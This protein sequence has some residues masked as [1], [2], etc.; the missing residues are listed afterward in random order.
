MDSLNIDATKK[1]PRVKFDPSGKFCL[2]GRSI[3][4]DA[5]VFYDPLYLWIFEYCKNPAPKTIVDV[6]LEYFNSGSSKTILHILRELVDLSRAGHELVINWYYE[7]GDDDIQERGEYYASILN[8]R[9]NF[10][11]IEE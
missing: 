2:S 9:L 8:Y 6:K 10:H 7:E 1:T 3:P 11:E 5:T 4:E